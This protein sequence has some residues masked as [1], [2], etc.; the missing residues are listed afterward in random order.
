MEAERECCVSVVHADKLIRVE[1]TRGGIRE[2]IQRLVV[3]AGK[4]R[5]NGRRN[6]VKKEARDRR[7]GACNDTIVSTGTSIWRI[8]A[9][10]LLVRDYH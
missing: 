5:R 9:G 6:E 4:R 7:R 10:F 3:R 2:R 1:N 8:F